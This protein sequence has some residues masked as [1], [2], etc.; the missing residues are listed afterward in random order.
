[1]KL[2]S[3]S[4][5][6]RAQDRITQMRPYSIK[7]SEILGNVVQ[8]LR[9]EE[10][11]LN[12]AEERDE[13]EILIVLLTSD[14]GLCGAFNTNL[15]KAAKHQINEVYAD[16]AKAGNVTLMPIGKKGFDAFK[17]T[18]IPIIKDYIDLFTRQDFS[19]VSKVAEM[20]MDAF[21]S[22]RFDKVL[23]CFAEFRNAATQVFDAVQFLPIPMM[24][25]GEEGASKVMPDYIFEPDKKALLEI[26]IPKILKT[27]FFRYILDNF[28]SE[29]GARMVAM[30]KAS[31]NANELLK[32]LRLAYNRE[33][34]AAIT[35]EI[36]EI[37]AGAAALEQG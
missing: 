29:H 11:D 14:K 26:L 17:N 24:D 31:E 30:D 9:G 18:D 15:I 19:E 16:Q 3:A 34:Q 37:V 1:M 23:V 12:F 35:T 21:I 22:E 32:E 6:K 7:L 28:A 8:S 2:V 13:K 20:I 10:I 33:R 25:N 27:Q 4:K 5:L 36:L